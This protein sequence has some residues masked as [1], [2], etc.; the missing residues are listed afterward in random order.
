MNMIFL[1]QSYWR[2]PLEGAI[3][4]SSPPDFLTLYALSPHCSKVAGVAFTFSADLPLYTWRA[5][6]AGPQLSRVRALPRA[7]AVMRA[8]ARNESNCWVQGCRLLV[9]ALRY[10]PQAAA[11]ERTSKEVNTR[12]PSGGS[13]LP[14]LAPMTAVTSDACA[15]PAAGARSGCAYG[16]SGGRGPAVGQGTGPQ[17]AR[18][19]AALRTRR[20]RSADALAN[21]RCPRASCRGADRRA[22]TVRISVSSSVATHFVGYVRVL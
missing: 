8:D 21:F 10:A 4:K 6:A 2:W 7:R 18:V 22:R 1:L 17:V 5:C 16:L 12:A 19:S 15:R 14:S 9:A 13:T 3:S 11:S 20:T